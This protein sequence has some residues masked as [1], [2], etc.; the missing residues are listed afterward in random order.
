MFFVIMLGYALSGPIWWVVKIRKNR[1]KARKRKI[2]LNI[3]GAIKL[4]FNLVWG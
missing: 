3:L 2:I 1:Q 4:D